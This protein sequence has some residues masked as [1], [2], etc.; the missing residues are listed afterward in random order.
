MDFQIKK[1]A[2]AINAADAR[3]SRW[4][5]GEILD[6]GMCPTPT[7]LLFPMLARDLRGLDLECFFLGSGA[8][9]L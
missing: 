8:I 5:G 2:I 4:T 1:S 9:D 3:P 7:I 6:G